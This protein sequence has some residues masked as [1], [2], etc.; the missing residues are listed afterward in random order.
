MVIYLKPQPHNSVNICKKSALGII[1]APRLCRWL[2]YTWQSINS[3]PS[4]SSI[5]TNL[6]NANLLALLWWLNMLSPKKILPILTPYKPP[7]SSFLCQTSALC[8]WPSRCSCIN[9]DS[10]S[11]VIQ[12]PFWPCR[13][14][15]LHAFITSAND[16]LTVNVNASLL[17]S[18]CIDLL[19]FNSPGNNTNRGSGL[20]QS[21]TG[22]SYQ[23]KIPLL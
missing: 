5:F 10:I 18:C 21:G 11:F 2:V 3:T 23:G 14:V 17:S 9:A 16:W 6:I 12:V 19:I 22:P 4:A 15:C 8:A 13:G 20:H 1:L 7:H